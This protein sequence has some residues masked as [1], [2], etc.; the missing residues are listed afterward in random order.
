VNVHLAAEGLYFV[1]EGL[2]RHFTNFT[3]AAL[4]RVI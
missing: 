3:L 1:A 4:R 2:G